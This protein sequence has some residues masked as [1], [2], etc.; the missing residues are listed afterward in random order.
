[1][2]RARSVLYPPRMGYGAGV[3]FLLPSLPAIL[4]GCASAAAGGA[5]PSDGAPGSRP[6]S[7]PAADAPAAPM[8]AAGAGEGAR[9][10]GEGEAARPPEGINDRW[11]VSTPDAAAESLERETREVY[12]HREAVVSA[13]ELAP[14]ERVADIG[15]GTGFFVRLF[16]DRV[17]P[18]GKVYGVDIAPALVEGI[19]TW[20][21]A[22][23]AAHVKGVL[24]ETDDIVLPEDSVD[25]VF[26]SDTYHHFEA[27]AATLASVRR[28]LRPGGRLFVLDF[29]RIPGTSP[30]WIL[31][32]VRAGKRTVVAE[33]EQAGFRFVRELEVPGLEENYLIELRAP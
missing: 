3:R 12:A 30:G 7:A 9:T 17:G 33:L 24:G 21:E 1:M 32:H 10:E 23:G 28:A 14:G 6:A 15:A 22:S 16:A 11:R 18:E 31:E 4:L 19:R 29:E 13:L 25:V 8:G 20:A 5:R 26:T 27:P 2:K